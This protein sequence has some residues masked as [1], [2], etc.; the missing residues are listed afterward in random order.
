MSSTPGF[1]TC[2]REGQMD[3]V[4][5]AKAVKFFTIVLWAAGIIGFLIGSATDRFL[6]AFLVLFAAFLVCGLTVIPSWPIFNRN[7]LQF[8]KVKQS[9]ND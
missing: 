6:N 2:L 9:K 7:R 3:F 5:Q 8:Q 1:F 4:G